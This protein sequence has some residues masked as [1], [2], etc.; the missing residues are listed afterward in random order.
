MALGLLRSRRAVPALIAALSHPIANLR[1]EAVN[2]LAAIGDPQA[3]EALAHL[4][5]DGDVEVRKAVARALAA[6]EPVL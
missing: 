3:R 1:R 5:Q 2:A 6:L 4:A